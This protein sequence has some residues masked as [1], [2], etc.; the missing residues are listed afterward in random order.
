MKSKFSQ[1]LIRD[2]AAKYRLTPK[3]IEDIV[4]SPFVFQHDVQKNRCDR[5]L[6]IYPNVRI[7]NFGMF[8]VVDIIKEK[9]FKNKQNGIAGIRQKD[10]G[11]YNKSRSSTG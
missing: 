10:V 2:L 5:H 6:L 3:Q 4:R 9:L 11:S 1:Q 8:L 7:P